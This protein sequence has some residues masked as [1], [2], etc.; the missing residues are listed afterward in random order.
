[1]TRPEWD[2]AIARIAVRQHGV[3]SHSQL[4][5]IGLSQGAICHRVEAGRLH[6]LHRGVFAVGCRPSGPHGHWMAATLACGPRSVLSHAPA[7][8]LSGLRGSSAT[9]IDVTSPNRRGRYHRGIRI[10]G[11]DTLREADRTEIGGIPCTTVARLI[12]DLAGVLA[13]QPLEYLI[14]R[15]QTKG[16]F[17]RDELCAVVDY[18]PSRRGT[19]NVRRILGLSRPEEDELNSELERR[20][21]RICVA[22]GFP[23]PEV[24]KWV[25]SEQG[26]GFEVDFCWPEHGLIVE[27]DGRRFHGSSR[28]L[29][30]DPHRDRML[31]L[32][33]WTVIRF[34][35]RDLTERSREVARQLALL[36]DGTRPARVT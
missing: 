10:H 27:T 19:A 28:A 35:Y 21:F 34:T 12:V 11:A 13:L 5:E 33:G 24:N 30:N 26:G 16:V 22:Q 2:H 31:T 1:V 4:R 7:A 18:A 29:E 6:R 32:V 23:L 15:A 9:M 3:I 14:H 17:S 20:L 8:A 25:A 36:L